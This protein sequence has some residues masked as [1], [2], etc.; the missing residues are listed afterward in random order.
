VSHARAESAV[1][2]YRTVRL[3][4]PSMADDEFLTPVEVAAALR[5]SPRS[6]R[7]L[8]ERGELPAVR[9][10]PRITR[11]E[12]GQLQLFVRKAASAASPGGV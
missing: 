9:V 10:G 6:V 11:V 5:T 3:L 12:R 4:L 2:P 1:A 8:I 7:R